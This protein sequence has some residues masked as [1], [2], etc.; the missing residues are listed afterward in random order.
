MAESLLS[1]NS[2]A[3][4]PVFPR[5]KPLALADRE[6]FRQILWDYQAETSELTFTNLFIWQSYYG[7]QW[8]RDRDRLLVVSAVPGGEAW[9]L[10]PVGPSP[11]VDLCRQVLGWLKDECGVANP[12]I[13]RA[14][15]RLAAE[16]PAT[17]NSWWSLCEIILITSTAPTIS[18]IWLGAT[19]T[20]SA[21]TS[22]VWPGLTASAMNPSGKNTCQPV[23]TCAPGGAR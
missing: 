2:S 3:P 19:T 1:N 15:P 20:P 5:F 4:E 17:P 23:C 22:T 12:A 11:R 13:E 9:A 14:D 21:T 6:I 10:P 7:Y 8:S 16:L 18:S